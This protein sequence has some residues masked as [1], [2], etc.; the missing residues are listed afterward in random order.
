MNF[1]NMWSIMHNHSDVMYVP[2]SGIVCVIVLIVILSRFWEI[3]IPLM[4]IVI[5]TFL[6]GDIVRMVHYVRKKILVTQV[7]QVCR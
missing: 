2:R 3:A 6:Y 4:L 1:V 5:P 7:Q